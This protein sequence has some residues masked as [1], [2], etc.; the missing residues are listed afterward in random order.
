VTLYAG[1]PLDHAAVLT[2]RGTA[3]PAAKRYLAFLGSEG[4]RKILREFGYGVP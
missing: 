3:N 2:N 1:V 4:A